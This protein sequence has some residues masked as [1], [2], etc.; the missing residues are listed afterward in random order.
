MKD[1]EKKLIE[2]AYKLKCQIEASKHAIENRLQYDIDNEEASLIEINIHA[3][4]ISYDC[5]I[6]RIEMR[7]LT[8]QYA[9]HCSNNNPDMPF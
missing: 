9:D 4:E 1:F 3:M 7:H 6:R 2:G 8:K 5:L